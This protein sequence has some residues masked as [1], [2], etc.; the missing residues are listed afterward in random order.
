MNQRPKRL[1]FDVL[2]REVE[3][4][5]RRFAEVVDLRDVRMV[6]SAG[7]GGLAIEPADGVRG[8]R[9]VGA[10]HLHR[11]LATHAHVLGEI[12]AAHAALAEHGEDLVSIGDDL[13]DQA[14][15]GRRVRVAHGCSG[16]AAHLA[17]RGSN[18]KTSSDVRPLGQ[19]SYGRD[20]V[21]RIGAQN[22]R[23]FSVATGGPILIAWR[24]CSRASRFSTGKSTSTGT[25]SCS[26]AQ[27]RHSLARRFPS[28][29]WQTRSWES[30]STRSR[31]GDGPS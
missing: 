11:A 23:S 25:T 29:S 15:A 10:H 3:Q 31:R 6:D 12:D 1:A 2:H 18:W 20:S 22:V 14:I 24:S 19:T 13:S 30:G 5:V 28:S 17:W 21:T 4:A 9:H 27:A 8:E 26:A 16:S 7:V